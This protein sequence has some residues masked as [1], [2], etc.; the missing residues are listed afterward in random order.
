MGTVGNLFLD[1]VGGQLVAQILDGTKDFW[2]NMPI[3]QTTQGMDP[4]T[5]VI[6]NNGNF[7]ITRGDGAVVW[8]T[9]IAELQGEVRVVAML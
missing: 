2:V 8:A 7:V 4:F 6:K 3:E 1:G 5:A 9:N